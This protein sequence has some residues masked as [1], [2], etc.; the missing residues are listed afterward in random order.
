MNKLKSVLMTAAAA[1]SLAVAGSANAAITYKYTTYTGGTPVTTYNA[2]AGVPITIPI[3]LYE[4]LTSG[5]SSLITSEDGMFTAAFSVT[6][7]SN[8][9]TGTLTSSAGSITTNGQNFATDGGFANSSGKDSS[10][11]QGIANALG[12]SAPSGPLP[13]ASGDIQIGSVT[14]TTSVTNTFTLGAF[15]YP[16]TKSPDLTTTFTNG[17]DLDANS[18]SPAYTGAIANPETFSVV[19]APVPEPTS[20]ALLGISSLGLLARARRRKMA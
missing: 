11:F 13:N 12:G 20:A 16:A 17:D 18:T 15:N 7:T 1:A 5:S 6:Q 9:G 4:S 10:L 19:V 2:T 14:I 8:T 3:Y